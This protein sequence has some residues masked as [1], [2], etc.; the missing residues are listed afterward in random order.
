MQCGAF[1]LVPVFCLLIAVSVFDMNCALLFL[2]DVLDRGFSAENWDIATVSAKPLVE[3]LAEALAKSKASQE[4][5]L[6]TWTIY[7]RSASMY[8]GFL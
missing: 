8:G 3:V 6:D 7:A 5:V 1:K 2:E 4:A